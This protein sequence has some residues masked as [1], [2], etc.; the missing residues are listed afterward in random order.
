MCSLPPAWGYEHCGL[1]RFLLSF[2]WMSQSD[3]R[4]PSRLIKQEAD[5]ELLNWAKRRE[6]RMAFAFAFFKLLKGLRVGCHSFFS[7]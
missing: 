4:P 6:D 3:G 1:E 7:F 5:Q 2:P